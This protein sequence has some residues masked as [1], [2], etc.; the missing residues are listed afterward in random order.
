MQELLKIIV[1]LNTTT[2]Y[3]VRD[4]LQ[5]WVT[6]NTSCQNWLVSVKDQQ[7]K[8][9]E[10]IYTSWN[11]ALPVTGSLPSCLSSWR[12][13]I[14][15]TLAT[16]S[17]GS[18]EWVVS[19]L[20]LYVVGQICYIIWYVSHDSLA[21]RQYLSLL[22]V[23]QQKTYKRK[24]LPTFKSLLSQP[25]EVQSL[26]LGCL[27][28]AAFTSRSSILPYW[29]LSVANLCCKSPPIKKKYINIT[30]SDG[31]TETE[32]TG[33]KVSSMLFRKWEEWLPPGE[34][35]IEKRERKEN[36]VMNYHYHAFWK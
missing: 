34:M 30:L 20:L 8:Q 19:C 35:K 17:Q 15:T 18:W 16:S 32:N 11:S 36:N 3:T 28:T 22:R 9:P 12:G 21:G 27:R 1:R 2:V 13:H 31:Q 24:N 23:W 25:N 10:P 6:W 5:K 4:A 14:F 26:V 33:N 7:Q 29:N